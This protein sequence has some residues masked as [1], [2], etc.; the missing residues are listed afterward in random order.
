MV[1]KEGA[2]VG[3]GDNDVVVGIIIIH[4]NSES[5]KIKLV[6]AAA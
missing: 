4:D 6:S 5:N 1:I 3:D 2:Y